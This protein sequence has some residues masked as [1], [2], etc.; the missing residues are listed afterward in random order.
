[1]HS[2]NNIRYDSTEAHRCK[3]KY[4]SQWMNLR[5]ES[6]MVMRLTE[7]GQPLQENQRCTADSTSPQNCPSSVSS[8]GNNIGSSDVNVA[9]LWQTSKFLAV[10]ASNFETLTSRGCGV[11]RAVTTSD[12]QLHPLLILTVLFQ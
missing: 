1:L 12:T 8:T 3:R 10:S 2:R 6:G 11:S 7:F 9:S 5:S 4:V